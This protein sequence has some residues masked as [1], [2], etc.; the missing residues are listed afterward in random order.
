MDCPST[1]PSDWWTFGVICATF[2]GPIAAVQAQK[3]LERAQAK[4]NRKEWVFHILMTNRAQRLSPDFIRGLNTIDIA[5]RSGDAKRTPS[6]Q[7]V[8]DVWRDYL[9]KLTHGLPE[10]HTADQGKQWAD[11]VENLAVDLYAAIARD[12]GY[13]FDRENLRSGGYSTRGDYIREQEQAIIR[14]GTA[15]IVQGR[16]AVPVMIVPPPEQQQPP[17]AAA[18]Q[19]PQAR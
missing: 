11:E 10:G 7:R 6:E 15:D 17:G 1:Q 13:V 8:I 19:A 12:L 3:F 4:K 18:P 2:F 9:N 14:A 5:F 16:R